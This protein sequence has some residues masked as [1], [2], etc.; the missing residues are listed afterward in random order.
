M[1][2]LEQRLFETGLPVPSLMEKAALRLAAELL[3]RLRPGPERPQACEHPV[4]GPGWPR[5]EG[6]LV[7]VGPGH[8]GGDGLVVARELHLAG[9]AVRIWSPFERHK[10]L[11]EAHLRHALWLG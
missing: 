7:L 11:T 10:P 5:Q 4:E 8:N 1:A 2:A 3:I 6:V 9:V